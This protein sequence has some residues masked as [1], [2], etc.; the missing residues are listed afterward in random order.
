MAKILF[1][2]SMLGTRE[3]LLYS[4]GIY[5]WV[6]QINKDAW[7]FSGKIKLFSDKCYDSLLKLNHIEH[8]TQ[9][10]E[11]YIKSCNLVFKNQIRPW[12]LVMSQKAFRVHLENVTN[13]AIGNIKKASTKYYE[14]TWN[15]SGHILRSLQPCFVPAKRYEEILKDAGMN[16][17]VVKSFQA[18]GTGMSRVVEYDRFST[19]TGRLTVHSGPMVLT[20]KREYRNSVASVFPRG[21]IVSVDFS[22]LEARIVLQERKGKNNFISEDLYQKINQELFQGAF[23]RKDIKQFVLSE[24][25][26]SGVKSLMNV[27]NLPINEIALAAERVK[28]YF[29]AY[30]LKKEL[31]EQFLSSGFVQ[32]K[33]GRM[34][35][36]E[37]SS[38]HILLNSFA[39]STGVDVSLL[40]FSQIVSR[41]PSDKVR[42]IFLIH[43][44][45]Y[46]DVDEEYVD[47]ILALREIKI[48]GFENAFYVK[49]KL[50]ETIR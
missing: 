29:D 49:S 33:F 48:D 44:E 27:V 2:K 30:D 38:E 9:P 4:E 7:H 43:D 46:L 15:P 21:K 14:Q 31:K 39:Q 18:D 40:G 5:A 26:G 17:Q 24:M 3:H 25:Y 36:I 22:S 20:M 11:K 8:V 35:R 32:N 41:F 37:D 10:P 1:D 13:A 42:P 6:S 12:S 28:R 47:Q 45:M 19:R 23:D 34:I 16:H 50:I